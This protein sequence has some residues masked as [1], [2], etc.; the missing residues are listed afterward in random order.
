V[1]GAEILPRIA[2]DGPAL[3]DYHTHTDFSC[4]CSA[5]MESMCLAAGQCGLSEIAF[6]EHVDEEPADSCH[7]FFR[8]E[9][10]WD[11]IERCR[12]RFAGTLTIRAGVEVGEPHRFPT[13]AERMISSFPWDFVLAS[14]HWVGGRL[15][16]DRAYFDQPEPSAYGAYFEDLGVMVE[17]AEFD[18]LAHADIVKRYGYHAY[19]PFQVERYERSLR[20]ILSALARRGKGL[21]INTGPL[22]RPISE[23]SPGE[24]ILRWF[25]E[26]GGRWITIGSDAH[27]PADVGQGLPAAAALARRAGFPG[28]ATLHRRTFELTPWPAED[29]RGDA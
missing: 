17:Q 21:E 19:G 13:Q 8:A 12:A 5:S 23:T 7:G 25:A 4:D 2:R 22:R 28:T 20:P 16:F 3:N 29:A 27:T 6:T 26:E 15:V 11:E 9:A 10:W 1:D 18:I 24:T 14:L